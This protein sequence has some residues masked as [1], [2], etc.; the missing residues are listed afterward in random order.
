V[1]IANDVTAIIPAF[2]CEATIQR[3]L[4]SI[5]HQTIRPARVIV[6]D[7]CSS[8]GTASRVLDAG[9]ELA[10]EVV[11]LDVNCGPAAARQAGLERVTSEFTGFL[12]A[13]DEWHPLHLERSLHVLRATRSAGAVFASAVI[14]GTVPPPWASVPD[15]EAESLD[16]ERLVTVN[17][18]VQSS[19][20]ARTSALLAVGGYRRGKRHAEDYDLWLRLG[21]LYP[22]LDVRD[23]HVRRY[24][25]AHQISL[26]RTLMVAGKWEAL[27]HFDVW[28]ARN[29]PNW[30]PARFRRLVDLALDT[31]MT[32]AR[33]DWDRNL[34]FTILHAAERLSPTSTRVLY[35][36]QW[37]RFVWPLLRSARYCVRELAPAI[38][39]SLISASVTS[40]PRP[41]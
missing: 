15:G 5:A 7:D 18:I 2:N 24:P 4:H 41:S 35:W 40:P 9:A 1:T 30:T 22:I 32:L 16:F 14:V 26:S 11:R 31:D 8:D 38:R 12:D 33:S 19:V 28:S 6:V 3:A 39:S 17:P 21:S 27:V 34:L 13:D 10:V 36:K 25:S 29:I 23:D 37:M 20:V